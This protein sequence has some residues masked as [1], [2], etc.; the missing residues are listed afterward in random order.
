MSNNHIYDMI[1]VGGGPGGYTAALYAARSG[2]A[3]CVLEKLSAGGQMALSSQIDNYSGFEDGIDGFTLAEKMQRHAEKFGAKSEYAEVTA[4]DLNSNPKRLETSEGDFFGKTVVI[5]TGANPRELG[6]ENEAKLVGRGVAYCASCDGMAFRGKTVA[7][8]GGGNSAASDAIL[9]S[10]IAKKVII[11]HRR[12]KLRATKIYH[13]PLMKAENIEFRW[14][15]TVE[16]LLFDERLTG[17]R[18]KNVSTGREDVVECDGV[19]ISVGRKP[20]TDLVKGQIELDANGYIIAGETTETNIPGVYAVG[21]V[22]TK[23]LRQVITAA[24]DGAVAVHMAEEYIA[25]GA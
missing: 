21:D 20:A 2:L 8:V 22:R 14:N 15:S 13:D 17:V 19:F 4:V 11:I 12:D 23:V 24:S 3:V 7:V 18:L 5:A 9:L 10:R 25:G 6:I 16:E 1:I